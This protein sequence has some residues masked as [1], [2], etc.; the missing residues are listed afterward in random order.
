MRTASAQHHHRSVGSA[1]VV[2]RIDHCINRVLPH[3]TL[4]VSLEH[5]LHR[6]LRIAD[7]PA[8][9]VHHAFATAAPLNRM[10]LRSWIPRRRWVLTADVHRE[11]AGSDMVDHLQAGLRQGDHGTVFG[12]PRLRIALSA[13]LFCS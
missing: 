1:Q 13:N 12:N 8:S 9:R 6:Q 3:I 11:A 4:R 10:Q 2:D 7:Q 5:A